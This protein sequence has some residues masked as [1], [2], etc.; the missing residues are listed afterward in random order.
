MCPLG[1]AE[2]SDS[3]AGFEELNHV[4]DRAVHVWAPTLEALFE[5]AARAMFSLMAD[6]AHIRPECRHE[7][8]LEAEDLEAA[9]V[10]WLNALLFWRET[11]GE[12]YSEFQV[13]WEDGLLRGEFAGQPGH[14]TFAVV[15]AA[16]FHDLRIAQD[17][18]GLWHATIVFDT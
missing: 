7:I 2:T 12:M 16:T 10:D 1:M 15:K 9:L 13:R 3:P 11:Q 4:A 18:R 5:Q 17:E 6:L 14:P 8:T